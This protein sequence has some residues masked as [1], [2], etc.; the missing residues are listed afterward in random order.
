MPLLIAI[1][2][3]HSNEYFPGKK[4]FENESF[5]ESFHIN[6]DKYTNVSLEVNVAWKLFQRASAAR[7]MEFLLMKAFA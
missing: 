5:F 3:I 2:L 1:Q 4:S 6:T 7:G